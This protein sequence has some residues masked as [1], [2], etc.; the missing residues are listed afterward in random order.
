MKSVCYFFQANR[1]VMSERL[2]SPKEQ[3][4]ST[5]ELNH[6]HVST[7]CM[8]RRAGLT[9]PPPPAQTRRNHGKPTLISNICRSMVYI[10]QVLLFYP[11][12]LMPLMMPL[13][14]GCLPFTIRSFALRCYHRRAGKVLTCWTDS[15]RFPTLI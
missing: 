3:Q 6:K 5:I 11:A 1:R 2:A 13:T 12:A 9:R 15:F 7:T 10:L 8:S 14:A 4:C